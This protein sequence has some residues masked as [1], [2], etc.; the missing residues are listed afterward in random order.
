MWRRRHDRAVRLEPARR[1]ELEDALHVRTEGDLSV[2]PVEEQALGRRG[3]LRGRKCRQ[4]REQTSA[5]GLPHRLAKVPTFEGHDI[6]Q[7][8]HVLLAQNSIA[9]SFT[10][11]GTFVHARSR[12]CRHNGAQYYSTTVRI[13]GRGRTI[14]VCVDVESDVEESSRA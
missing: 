12:Y 2:V 14:T 4:Q 5:R 6:C 1:I 13:T 8:G 7:K 3:W 11:S 9:S 10:F